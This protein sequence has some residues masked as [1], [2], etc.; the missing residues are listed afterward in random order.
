[1][2]FA[3]FAI[4]AMANVNSRGLEKVAL[5]LKKRGWK[6]RRSTDRSNDQTNSCPNRL[7][8][9]RYRGTERRLNAAVVAQDCVVGVGASIEPVVLLAVQSLSEK[10][11]Q[12]IAGCRS[13]LRVGGY[14]RD[15]NAANAL[16]LVLRRWDSYHKMNPVL[17]MLTSICLALRYRA[18]VQVDRDAASQLLSQV[19]GCP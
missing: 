6:P 13:S 5:A 19:R 4:V 16:K 9:R 1:M 10:P 15:G 11:I 8:E 14:D 18:H 7:S 17:Q 12:L 3:A 2:K